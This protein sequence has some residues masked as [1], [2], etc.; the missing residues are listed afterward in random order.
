MSLLVNVRPEV[1]TSVSSLLVHYV[2]M[3]LHLALPG[4]V[5]VV[6]IVVLSGTKA[7]QLK[8]E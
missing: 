5:L 8:L 2:M 6:V 7:P 1:E 4:Q 3:A